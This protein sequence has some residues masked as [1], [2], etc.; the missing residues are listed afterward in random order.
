M[1][2]RGTWPTFGRPFWAGSRLLP[3][4]CRALAH[5]CVCTDGWVLPAAWTPDGQWGQGLPPWSRCLPAAP[6]L[7][8]LFPGSATGATSWQLLAL[9]PR[10]WARSPGEP[11]CAG[12]LTDLGNSGTARGIST[13]HWGPGPRR[14]SWEAGGGGPAGQAAESTGTRGADAWD[15]G[16]P[17]GVRTRAPEVVQQGEETREGASGRGHSLG[18]AQGSRRVG[19]GV[20]RVGPVTLSP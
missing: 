14:C 9:H 19:E 6:L 12:H 1:D 13:C 11:C 17:G 10:T 4:G 7:S 16:A 8:R 20:T 15:A 5:G 18:K 2:A 3:A